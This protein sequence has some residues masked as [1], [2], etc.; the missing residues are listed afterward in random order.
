MNN[1]AK[2]SIW[3]R[4]QPSA[5]AS[6]QPDA[7]TLVGNKNK[8]ST[9][10][11]TS[12]SWT[13][14]TKTPSEILT[15][16]NVKF[17]KPQPLMKKAHLNP[18][19]HF[20]FHDDIG[21]HTDECVT[22]KNDIEAVVKS[23]KLEHLIKIQCFEQLDEED[24]ARLKPIH[25]PVSGFGF[26]V[27]HPRGLISFC[28]TLSDRTHSRTEDVELLV[29]PAKSK[30][31]IILG[32]EAIGDFNAHPSTA[33]GAVGI[34]TRTG[35]AMIRVNKHYFTTESS[36]PIKISKKTER[37]EPEKKHGNLFL[38][39]S[40]YGRCSEKGGET[41]IAGKSSIYPNCA[42]KKWKMGPEQTRAMNEHVQDLLNV[43]IIREIQYQ[44]WVANPVIVP[45]R[46][47]TWRM[48]IDFKNWNKACS[49]YCYPLPEIDL[50]VGAIAP[51]KFKCFL[52]AY[53][54]YHQIRM[55][56][57]D[58]DKTVIGADQST[59]FYKMMPFRLKNAGATYQGLMDKAFKEQIGHTLEVYMDDL[60]IKSIEESDV[61]G[62]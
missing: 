10:T 13:Q 62:H 51:F 29:F 11:Q 37:T 1:P 16:E 58:E 14:L 30:H 35:V 12:N 52:N 21:H 48:C 17:R 36:K 5:K 46:N 8:A 55:A 41:Q 53:K 19:K 2:G 24:N 6:K 26:E 56:A 49:K 61:A 33:H 22:L 20:V 9:F 42:E 54:G 60:V 28:V 23:G 50:K 27:M 47:G 38:A 25:A 15:T 40:G 4:L 31:D 32:R 18:N 39:T 3:S 7:R 59:F 57:S 43:G 34:P 44:T 45:K